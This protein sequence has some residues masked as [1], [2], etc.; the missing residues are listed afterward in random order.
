MADNKFKLGQILKNLEELKRTLLT[1]LANQAQ[2]FFVSSWDNQ[3]WEGKEWPEPKCRIEETPE[4]KYPKFKGLG[5]RTQAILVKTGRLRRAVS[6][7]ISIQSWPTVKIM[8]D[9]PYAKVQNEG[10]LDK[11]IPK[12]QYMGDSKTLKRLQRVK[13]NEAV[14]TVFNI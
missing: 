14:D 12:R 11:G 2:Y 5:R 3:G 8:V 9:L 10:D 7:S 1:I 13:I 6:N 4:Y